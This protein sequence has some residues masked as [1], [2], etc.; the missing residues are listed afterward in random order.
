VFIIRIETDEG[1]QHMRVYT[2]GVPSR[3]VAWCACPNTDEGRA[4]LAF[5]RA[6]WETSPEAEI[7]RLAM[8]RPAGQ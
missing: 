3:L 2:R 6:H 5:M 8:V 1:L 4:A 7:P